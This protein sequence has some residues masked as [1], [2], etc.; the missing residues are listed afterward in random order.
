MIKLVNR[1]LM[2]EVRVEQ[3]TAMM[4]MVWKG[5]TGMVP[6]RAPIKLPQA[7]DLGSPLIRRNLRR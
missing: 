6:I 2:V 7:I 3:Q 1:P 4:P 5:I